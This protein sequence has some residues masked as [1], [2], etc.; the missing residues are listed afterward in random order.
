MTRRPTMNVTRAR[1]ATKAQAMPRPIKNVR[2]G[3][4]LSPFCGKMPRLLP[5]IFNWPRHSVSSEANHS[6]LVFVSLPGR[7]IL[8]DS[9]DNRNT[10]GLK[11]LID[12]M[13]RPIENVR[14]GNILSPFCG[15]MPQLLPDLFNWPR[16]NNGQH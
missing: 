6:R 10:I 16:H 1:P 5:D 14:T 13:P 4:I 2:I 11:S 8:P 9:V 15:K 7:R 12:G 3:D